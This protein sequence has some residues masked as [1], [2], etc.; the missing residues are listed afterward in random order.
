MDTSA[1][2]E[3]RA[4]NIG[5]QTCGARAIVLQGAVMVLP[6]CQVPNIHQ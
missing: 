3:E 2:N 1:V 6:G 4:I 5:G